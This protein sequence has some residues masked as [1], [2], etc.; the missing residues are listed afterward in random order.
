MK[1]YD[2]VVI[3]GGPA[4][5]FCAGNIAKFG[6]SVALVE[7]NEK[8]GRKLLIT[9]KGRCNIT[10]MSD[11]NELISALTKNNK[12]MYSA[13]SQFDAYDTVSFFED[14]GVPIKVERGNRVFPVSDKSVD[15]VDCL[16]NY[17]LNSGVEIINGT[18]IEIEKQDEIVNV[19]CI[20]NGDTIECNYLVVATG[21]VSYPKT[22]STGDGYRF[23]K[24]LGH[25]IIEPLGSL[26]PLNV[27]EG[28][29]SDCQGLSLKN[30]SIKVE[31]TKLNKIIYTDFGE[32]L[33]T[34]FGLSGPM[35]LSASAHMRNM[36]KG[37]YKVHID[38]KPALDCEKLDLRILRDFSE[39]SNK[40]LLNSLSKLLPSK[41]IPAIIKVS[42]IDAKQKVNQITK[43]QREKLVNCIKDLCFTVTSFRPIEEAI[44]TS[45]GVDVKDVDPKTCC[46]KICKNLYFAGEVLDV[47]AYT[48]GYN[49]QIAFSTAFCVAKAIIENLKQGERL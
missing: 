29:A 43:E 21:G 31:D 25:N 40:I 34:H 10:N 42:G 35:I 19:V 37:R 2:V 38:L 41:I 16:Y 4:G 11:K 8:V 13:F 14:N 5:L 48:G 36:E 27:V 22:G 49:L 32:M 26:V 47:D 17:V 20:E 24:S 7:K 46:S 1:K 9:G 33:F 45:G 18:V 28:M 44:V 30:V 15:V 39:N 3:G 12:F 23:A 6:C